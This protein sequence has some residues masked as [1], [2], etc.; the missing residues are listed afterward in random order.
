MSVTRTALVTG[1]NR[2]IGFEVC[3]QLAQRSLRVILT[4]RN[5][6]HGEAATRVLRDEENLDVHYV[7]MDVSSERSVQR[8]AAQLLENGVHVDVLVNNAAV[9]PSGSVLH[10]ERPTIEEAL[11]VNLLGPLWTS[12]VWVPAMLHEGYGRVVNVSSGWGAFGEG[13]GGPVAYSVPKAALNALTVKLATEVSGDI[14]VNAV[15]PGWVRTRMG[16]ANATLSVETGADTIVW[17]A[18]LPTGGPNGGFFR[19]RSRIAW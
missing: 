15:C 8:C 12:Q 17:L 16:G 1:G 19:D 14:N 3:R 4:S 5:A 13:M 2:G 10:V 9:C 7:E 18:T 6:K 11:H